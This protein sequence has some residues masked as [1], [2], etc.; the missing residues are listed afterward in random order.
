MKFGLSHHFD[1]VSW[2]IFLLRETTGLDF[3]LSIFFI[4][5]IQ[6]NETKFS[7]NPPW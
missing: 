6:S 7:Q 4:Q 5:K 3:L 2:T 1:E